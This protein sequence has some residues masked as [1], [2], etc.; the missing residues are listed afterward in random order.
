[1]ATQYATH[2]T[3]KSRPR[4]RK[5]NSAFRG[6]KKI[7]NGRQGA[8]DFHSPRGG[9]SGSSSK[10]HDL[11]R[12]V[13]GAAGIETSSDH[14]PHDGGVRASGPAHRRPLPRGG[15]GAHCLHGF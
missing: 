5:L 11:G 14:G 15:V 1:M 13:T 12:S 9:T 8:Y 2:V 6:L 10:S 4:N 7:H 3:P